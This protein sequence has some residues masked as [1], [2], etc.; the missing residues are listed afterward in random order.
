MVMGTMQKGRCMYTLKEEQVGFGPDSAKPLPQV[1]RSY[2]E[3]DAVTGK[4]E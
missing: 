3:T 2:S 4:I 1:K